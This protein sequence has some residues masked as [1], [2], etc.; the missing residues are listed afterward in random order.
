[1]AV[2]GRNRR[3]CGRDRRMPQPASS[4][5]GQDDQPRTWLSAPISPPRINWVVLTLL[6]F[7]RLADGMRSEAEGHRMVSRSRHLSRATGGRHGHRRHA[8][9]M[10][11]NPIR[12]HASFDSDFPARQS[13]VVGKAPAAHR[14]VLVGPLYHLDYIPF[15]VLLFGLFVVAGGI[16]IK[17]TI[18][19]TTKNNVILLAIGT[20]LASWI[21]T[22]GAA[23]L[24][25][26]ISAGAVFMGAM[27]YIG[28]APNFMA[29][30]IAERS[31]VK[32]PSFFGYMGWSCSIRCFS[33]CSGL[34]DEG[35]RAPSPRGREATTCR[36]W[37]S[38]T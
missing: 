9:A 35:F 14:L 30:S 20:I 15:I 32:M 17:G 12:R 37:A 6:L 24:L 28:N 16:H 31:G 10:E 33:F 3:L 21:G 13:R 34:T 38:T 19:G 29:K 27:T 23:M 18:A 4:P 22:T 36:P 2:L 26:A 8:P 25:L 5:L 7:E 1:M 11:H